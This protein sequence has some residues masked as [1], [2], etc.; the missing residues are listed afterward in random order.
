M[1]KKTNFILDL[2]RKNIRSTKKHKEK[3]N[4]IY[5]RIPKEDILILLLLT[6]LL[7]IGNFV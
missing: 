3:K 5:S 6:I 7:L 1:R 2:I 4:N